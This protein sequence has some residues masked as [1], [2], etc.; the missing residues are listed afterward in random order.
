MGLGLLQQCHVRSVD[1]LEGNQRS[2]PLEAESIL[3]DGL[4]LHIH[5][6]ERRN[7]RCLHRPLHSDTDADTH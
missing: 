6:S 7:L 4:R 5:V 3:D 2:E 1:I